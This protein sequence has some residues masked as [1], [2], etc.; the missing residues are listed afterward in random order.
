M[1]KVLTIY[2]Q[3]LDA[4]KPL[5]LEYDIWSYD[6]ERPRRSVDEGKWVEWDV[7]RRAGI[8]KSG[9]RGRVAD[10]SVKTSADVASS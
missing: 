6:F 3:E 7:L 5:M 10:A 2:P 4:E 1:D 9:T 8:N